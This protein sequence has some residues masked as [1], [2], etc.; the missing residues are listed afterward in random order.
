MSPPFP[1]RP[2]FDLVDEDVAGPTEP[3]GGPEVVESGG[4]AVDF[5]QD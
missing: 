4:G 2:G 3:G 1:I 5:V